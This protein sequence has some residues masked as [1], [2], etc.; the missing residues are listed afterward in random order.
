M[1]LWVDIET[2]SETDLVKHG[3]YP[4]T[5]DP[6]FTVILMAYALDDGPVQCW[7]YEMGPFHLLDA[8]DD[9][10]MEVW[11]HNAEFERVCIKAKWS[12]EA[13]WRCSAVLAHS[14]G[15]PP[16]LADLARVLGVPGKLDSG[17]KLLEKFAFG[18]KKG[19]P[20]YKDP[21]WAEFKAY[22]MQDVEAARACTKIM[23]QAPRDR[24][25]VET[26]SSAE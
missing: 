15:L 8:F 4:Y 2:Y 11:A 17:K 3:V 25:E 12:R 9:P 6:R 24:T 20:N 16:R 26:R 14:L 1:R 13:N 7:S 23:E 22:C 18:H 10:K 19:R 5:E 21:D